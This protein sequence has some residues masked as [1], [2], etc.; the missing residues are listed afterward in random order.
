MKPWDRRFM[1][2]L[3]FDE[4]ERMADPDAAARLRRI[5][6]RA[7]R[8]AAAKAGERV[9]ALIYA[10]GVAVWLRIKRAVGELRRMEPALRVQ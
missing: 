6:Q 1:E 2:R 9:A 3:I 5:E 4:L 7:R 8:T 10:E